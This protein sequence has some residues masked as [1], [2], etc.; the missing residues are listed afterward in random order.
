MTK[1]QIDCETLPCCPV[2]GLKLKM[3][4]EDD[5]S[6]YVIWCGDCDEREIP[7][8]FEVIPPDDKE[9]GAR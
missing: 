9:A 7:V 8:T 4:Y 3:R 6:K 5:R 2:C 1:K